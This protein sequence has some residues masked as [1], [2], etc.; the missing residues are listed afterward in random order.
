[1]MELKEDKVKKTTKLKQ[2][3]GFFMKY[4]EFKEIIEHE[5]II[6]KS[7]YDKLVKEHGEVQINLLFDKYIADSSVEDNDDKFNML[8]TGLKSM[9]FSP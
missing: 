9:D 8:A 3:R 2:E 7:F 4:E 1:M 6:D 5:S